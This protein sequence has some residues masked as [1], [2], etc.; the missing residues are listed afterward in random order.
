M[1]LGGGVL[2]GLRTG[3]ELLLGAAVAWIVIAPSLDPAT[4]SSWLLWPGVGMVLGGGISGLLLEWRTFGALGRDLRAFS[5]RAPLLLV[6]VAAAAVTAV[7]VLGLGVPP[8]LALV[9]I[10]LFV[11]LAAIFLRIAGTTDIAHYGAIG[12][13][14]Q[15]VLGVVTRRRPPPTS[16][17]GRSRPAPLPDA[18]AHLLLQDRHHRRWPEGA[19][20][21]GEPRRPRRRRVPLGAGVRRP[22]P[23]VPRRIGRAAC[24]HRGGVAGHGGRR[25][26]RPDRAP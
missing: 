7:A 22:R 5:G 20:H 26:G 13:V 12:Q 24:P 17:A 19:A 10:V 25:P 14:T 15:G 21:L 8:A 3:L 2:I 23:G 6:L 11:P 4:A 9:G 16:P 1:L 18:A